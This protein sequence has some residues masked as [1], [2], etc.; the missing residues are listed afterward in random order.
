MAEREY[1]IEGPDG[2]TLTIVGPDNATPDQLR[3]AAEKAFAAPGSAAPKQEPGLLDK[4]MQASRDTG[5]GALR[6]AG[7]IGATLLAPVDA[8]AR[9]L[10]VQNDFIGRTDRRQAMTDA[11]QTLGSDP[12]SALYQV[13]KLG[14]EIAGTA[15]AGGALANLVGRTGAAPAFVNA[16]RTSGASGSMPQRVAAGATVGGTSAAMVDPND[17]LAGAGIGGAAPALIRGASALGQLARPSVNN[18][19]LAQAAMDKYG[20]PLGLADVTDSGMT[21]AARTILNDAPL[22]GRVGD[23]QKEAVQQAFNAAIGDT[24]GAKAPKLTPQVMDAAKQRMGAEFDRL[25]NGNTLELDAGFLRTVQDLQSRAQKLPS[26]E[27][28]SLLAEIDDLL[29]KAVPGPNGAPT[30]SGE[31]ANAFQQHLRRRV[32]GS[33]TLRNELGE[34]RQGILGAFGRSVSPQD[35]A[36]LTLNRKQ[37]K[38]FKTVQPLLEGAEA[39]VAG[40]AP[41]DVP[42]GLLPGAVRKSYSDGVAGSPLAE[43]SQI[44]SQYVAD[45]VARTGGSNRAMIQNSAIGALLGLGGYAEPT[46]ALLALPAAYGTQKLLGSN[47]AARALV[48]RAAAGQAAPAAPSALEILLQRSAPVVYAD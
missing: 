4:A 24:F 40:R 8:A 10:G 39:G 37:Y 18:A 21:K 32:E 30:I 17:A 25:W 28:S 36:A 34:L 41:G 22:V 47:T 3:A 45:R 42:A 5:L 31:A 27:G 35:A 38:A 16:L 7:S 15:G 48:E 26:S 14:G 29:S 44:G 19:P 11:T 1:K 2:R 13:G 46:T 43:L 9:A 6:G 20:I 33:Q 12:N 23:K